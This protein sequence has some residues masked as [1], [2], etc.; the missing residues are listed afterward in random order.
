MWEYKTFVVK[1][2]TV[3]N[4]ID[5]GAACLGPG[6]RG[7]TVSYHTQFGGEET[8]KLTLLE[9]LWV[10]GVPS[11]KYCRRRWVYGDLSV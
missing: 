5:Q 2:E 10:E 7:L 11:L 4:L 9:V 6:P 8:M 3:E 1:P